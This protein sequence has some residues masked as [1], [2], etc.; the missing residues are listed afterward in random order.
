MLYPHISGF[1]GINF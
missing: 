1:K